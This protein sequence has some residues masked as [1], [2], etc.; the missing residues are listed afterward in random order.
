MKKTTKAAKPHFTMGE[1]V[2][3]PGA[4][5]ALEAAGVDP[6][7]LLSRHMAGDWGDLDED[8]R[9]ANDDAVKDGEEILSTYTLSTGVE[10]YIVTDAADDRGSRA[11]TRI[12]LMD[13]Y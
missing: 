8:D 5:E 11:T 13:E 12:L 10:V 6:S 3:T 1:Q 2:T 4:L 9:L 7:E